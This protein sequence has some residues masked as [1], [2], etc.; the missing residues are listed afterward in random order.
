MP[1]NCHACSASKSSLRRAGLGNLASKIPFP[2]EILVAKTTRQTEEIQG[3]EEGD[4]W[5][6]TESDLSEALSDN[7][8]TSQDNDLEDLDDLGRRLRDC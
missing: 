1:Q 8:Y 5:S 6:S 3:K 2:V 7:G 4:W